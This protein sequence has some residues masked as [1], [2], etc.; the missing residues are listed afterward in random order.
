MTQPFF[1]LSEIS[2]FAVDFNLRTTG[3]TVKRILSGLFIV[4]GLL[5]CASS[6]LA[7][8]P[9]TSEAD[10]GEPHQEQ[11]FDPKEM[12][13]HHIADAHDWHLWDATDEDGHTH[14]VSIPLPVILFHNGNVDIFLSSAFKHG[15]RP[16]T[17]GDRTYVL[18][19]GDI[20]LTDSTGELQFDEHH[21]VQNAMPV[22]LSITKNVAAMFLSMI[23]L[24]WLFGSAARNYKK[25]LVPKGVAGILE[26]LVLFV[27]DDIAKPNIDGDKYKRYLPFLLTVF[28]FIWINNLLG[29]IPVLSPNL[30]GNIA[31]TMV[32]ALFTL[33]I[34]NFS[35]NK[36]YW[37]HI[38]LPPVPWWLY[39]IMIPV[40]LIGIFT[41]PF[42]LMIR[43]FANITAGHILILSLVSLIFI[44]KSV[45]MSGLSVPFMVFMNVLELLVAVLQAYIF[46][47]LSALFIGM[48]TA[49]AHH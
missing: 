19:H 49:E 18:H 11:K 45:A 7:G 12:I 1:L 9:H 24:L 36:A 43:L 35:G 29:L 13:L 2:T 22:D 17:K 39:P 37:S 32:L 6:V 16:V 40:E 41:K 46:T 25:S 26:P 4:T 23:L 30:T 15:N 3:M 48:A 34:T 5:L 33:V 14:P 27:R 28:F 21:H 38:L 44:F 31:F 47:L 8:D 20:Y 10:H 42:A